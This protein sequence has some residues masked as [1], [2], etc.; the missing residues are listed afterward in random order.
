[1]SRRNR[2]DRVWF[3]E[4]HLYKDQKF[5][6]NVIW[7][8]ETKINL[9]GSDG[10]TR[11]WRKG[12]FP[13]GVPVKHFKAHLP[14]YVLATWLAQLNPLDQITLTILGER[15]NLW[16]FSLWSFRHASFVSVFG[17]NIRLR[18]KKKIQPSKC[19]E[20]FKTKMVLKFKVFI[21][22]GFF[23]KY[24]CFL[25]GIKCWLKWEFGFIIKTNILSVIFINLMTGWSFASFFWHQSVLAGP[26]MTRHRIAVKFLEIQSSYH[27]FR[28]NLLGTI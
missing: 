23:K 25:E 24:Y 8:D 5:W 22:L 15:Y 11:V 2:K 13:A 12:L 17:P 27:Y 18:I 14:S 1:M 7:W 3:A 6:K 20:Y 28:S 21:S 9:F 19:L 16:S 4:E 26:Q 10:I